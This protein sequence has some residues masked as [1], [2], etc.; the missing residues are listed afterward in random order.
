M[1]I[2]LYGNLLRNAA[3]AVHPHTGLPPNSFQCAARHH[4]PSLRCASGAVGEGTTRLDFKWVRALA[5]PTPWK[6]SSPACVIHRPDSVTPA[7]VREAYVRPL[8]VRPMECT[9]PGWWKGH[10]GEDNLSGRLR[11]PPWHTPKPGMHACNK[12]MDFWCMRALA[13]PIPLKPRKHAHVSTPAHLLRRGSDPSHRTDTASLQPP[14]AT[15]GVECR[16]KACVRP[17]PV[18]RW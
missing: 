15:L 16:R 7:T 5:T 14:P 11:A 9:A 1:M 18:R 8:P 2:H 17:L 6:P 12:R 13:T 3:T 4:L 10:G